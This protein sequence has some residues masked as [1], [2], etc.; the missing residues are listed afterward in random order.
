ML[1]GGVIASTPLQLT[2][3]L[4]ATGLVLEPCTH[5]VLALFRFIQSG[6]R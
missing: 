3:L 4:A 5:L 1:A 2:E 6:V